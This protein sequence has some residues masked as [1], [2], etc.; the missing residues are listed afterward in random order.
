MAASFMSAVFV[1]SYNVIFTEYTYHFMLSIIAVFCFA[2]FFKYV[3]LQGPR[4]HMQDFSA[5]YFF[6]NFHN[7]T[8]WGSRGKSIEL[9]VRPYLLICEKKIFMTFE[10]YC[11]NMKKPNELYLFFLFFFFGIGCRKWCGSIADYY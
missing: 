6:H 11:L 3:F 1:T 4:F 9:D 5:Y 2:Y 7:C 10:Q 8:P